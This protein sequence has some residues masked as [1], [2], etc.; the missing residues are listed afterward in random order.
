MYAT[1]S[2]VATVNLQPH[3]IQ[4]FESYSRAAEERIASQAQ[5]GVLLWAVANPARKSRTWVGGAGAVIAEPVVANGDVAAPDGVIH[6][7]IGAVFIPGTTL[8]RT[9]A[10]A[11]DYDSHA[12]FYWPEVQQSKLL[13]RD[14]N[15]YDIYLRLLKRQVI[16][17]VLDTNHRVR[18]FPIDEKRC[19]SISHSRRVADVEHP[20]EPGEIEMP[21]G[22]DHGFLWR[23]DSYWRFEQRDGGVYVECEAI[24]LSRS[25][26]PGLGWLVNPIIRNL[27]RESLAKT[28]G[29]LRT[30]VLATM[31]RGKAA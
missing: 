27:P 2:G 13:R 22:H 28:L 8:A 6:D 4:P 12:R 23:L 5:R 7:W 9:V 29:C 30:G 26:P 3:T 10:F 17:V 31:V 11:Q 21:P 1:V 25:V 15:E 24:S 16:T 19:Y 20:S 14:G 18:Y